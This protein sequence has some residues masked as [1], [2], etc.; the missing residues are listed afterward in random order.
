M[1]KALFTLFALFYV[2]GS[3]FSQDCLK[4]TATIVMDVN[5]VSAVINNSAHDFVINPGHDFHYE[6]PKGSGFNAFNVKSLWFSGILPSSDTLGAGND[7]ILGGRHDFYPGPISRLYPNACSQFDTLWTVYSIEIDQFLDDISDGTIDHPIPNNIL[8][9]P[10]KGNINNNQVVSRLGNAPFFDRSNNYIYEPLD[11]D[12]PVISACS[13]RYA[14]QMVWYVFNDL[15]EHRRSGGVPMNIQIEAMAYAFQSENHLDNTTFYDYTIYNKSEFDYSE[16]RIGL[17]QDYQLGD[18]SKVYIGIDTTKDLSIAYCSENSTYGYDNN[19]PIIGHKILNSSI[20]R[21]NDGQIVSSFVTEFDG[22]GCCASYPRNDVEFHNYLNGLWACG[23]PVKNEYLG[24]SNQGET[25]KFV[26][27]DDPTDPNGWSECSEENFTFG[28]R[29]VTAIHPIHFRSTDII[30]IS[31]A[32]LFV[33]DSIPHPCPSFQPIQ[34]VADFV[35]NWYNENICDDFVGISSPITVSLESTISPNPL[36]KVSILTFPEEMKTK[37][38]IQ[39]FNENGQLVY[40]VSATTY[41]SIE[42][43]KSDLGQGIFIYKVAAEEGQS[44]GKFVVQ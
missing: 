32:N 43:S 15:G 16:F 22:Q 10:A 29:S 30:K 40:T 42:I 8:Y 25:V 21:Q 3:T 11:G 23:N 28:R 12:Y 38:S 34:A 44:V 33:Q 2:S 9:W 7:Y 24:C 19:I 36:T 41:T 17:W 1:I 4:P 39:I 27:P 37:K 14:D 35:Q 13:D 6:I 26:F 5:N 20:R 18:F 31:F